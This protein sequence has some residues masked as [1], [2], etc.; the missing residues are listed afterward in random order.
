MSSKR[1][2]SKDKKNDAPAETAADPAHPESIFPMVLTSA[3]Q[4]LFACRADEDVTGDSPYKLLRKE[5]IIQDMKMRAAIS[6]FSPIKQTVLDYPG[7]ELLLVF[8]RD[9][10][11]GQSFYLVLT[12][13]A[14]EQI[15]KPAELE[16]GA[17]AGEQAQEGDSD[18]DVGMVTTPVSQP[19][20]PLGSDRE[21][22]DEIFTDS[23]PRLKYRISRVRREFG[24]PISFSDR[25][26]LETKDAFMEC[27][28]YEDKRFSLKEMEGSRGAQAIPDA[29]TASTQT[30]WT[31]PKNMCTQ[32]EPRQ[33]SEEEKENCL[34][35]E[36][37]K[38]FVQSVAIR[39][40]LA[41]QQNEI[42]D[43]F[44]DDWASLSEE[45][46]SLGGK[47]DTHLKE[48][49]SFTDLHHS[50][51][52]TISYIN[53]HPTIS[54]VIA[55][56][57]A[58]RLTFEE[59]VGGANKLVLN[60]S[61]ILF[62][63]FSD[64]INPQ[65]MLECPDDIFSFEFCLSDP[66]II[67][68]GCM[69]GQVV[70]WD[71][72]AHVDRLQG[73]RGGGGGGGKNMT[74]DTGAYGF[75]EKNENETP[76]VRYCAV[77]SIDSGHKAPITDI[78]W[79]PESFEL[80]RQGVPLENK[81]GVCV[82][83]VTCAPDCSVLVWDI[84]LAKFGSHE[85]E[86]KHKAEEKVHYN[87]NG[88]SNPFK[89]LDLCWKPLMKV[90]LPKI[91]SSGEYSPFKI[92]MRHNTTD[93]QVATL[94]PE[95][96][97]VPD[98]S[99]LRIPS[100]KQLKTV[101]DICTMFYVGTEDGEI[102]YTDWKLE[103][104]HESGK[105]FSRKPTHRYVTHDGSVNTVRRSP[106]FEDILL[107]VGGWRFAIWKEGVMNGPIFLSHYSQTRCTRGCWSAS[108]P[109]VF[110]IGK[111]D[112]CVEIWD[113][114]EKTHEPS[115]V[116]TISTARVTSIKPWIISSKQHLLAISD[117]FGTLHILEIPWTLRSTSASEKQNIRKYFDKEVERL[118]Y[119][120]KRQEMRDQEKKEREAEEQRLKA[121]P[122]E[123]NQEQLE[124]E[125][126]RAYEEYLSME[127]SILKDMG[128]LEDQSVI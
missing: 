119:F 86:R 54:G 5:D 10:T 60:P 66:N 8:D 94:H 64:P 107:T 111:E 6:D 46:G 53:W 59:R 58:E 76:M 65:L 33:F 126:A 40:E 63:S 7:D 12:V 44:F 124:E 45:D 31:Y 22:E 81:T 69:N 24:A 127:K 115:Q 84:R 43:V 57:M 47:A 3:T 18:E 4:E 20:V 25:N 103:K 16:S 27:V 19:W 125:A 67:V 87:P 23:R 2:K 89:H 96:V 71:I 50:K 34:K 21:V 62:W 110:F 61:L 121:Q 114:L 38:N 128:L 85:D 77:S 90:T 83:I 92:C 102:V 39:F 42:M 13:E 41:I 73:T 37:L 104:D 30:K 122:P 116:Q 72:S 97:E 112:G 26:A 101:D 98:Y 28:S 49:Q 15:L 99:M 56:A 70:L 109:S 91:D 117:H 78:Q 35:S 52:K 75:E 48:Y 88:A 1:P 105:L 120:E 79:L 17:G 100:P 74:N 51:E 123:K 36:N 118:I 29:Q 80:S 55:V 113:L 82:Q 11:Y 106:F 95:K 32:Y 93:I 9:F 14:M 108:R 68:G